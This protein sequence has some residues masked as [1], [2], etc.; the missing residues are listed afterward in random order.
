[1][2]IQAFYLLLPATLV[3]SIGFF[4]WF[5]ML[6]PVSL[7]RLYGD[8]GKNG[9]ESLDSPWIQSSAFLGITGFLLAAGFGLLAAW[10][11][12]IGG[13]SGKRIQDIPRFIWISLALGILAVVLF[14][15]F[16]PFD[17]FQNMT[18]WDGFVG[19]S[20]F[21]LGPL[22]SSALAIAWHYSHEKRLSLRPLATRNVLKDRNH[23]N[24]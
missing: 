13:Y 9:G 6:I 2:G 17:R 21:G 22:I 18:A 8:I 1:M 4:Y 19:I 20:M 7:F 16:V 24:K 14:A 12:L 5:I 23:G 10:W 15:E 11:L 3:Y